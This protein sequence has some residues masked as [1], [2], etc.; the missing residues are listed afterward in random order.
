M[1]NDKINKLTNWMFLGSKSRIDRWINK[2]I[3]W[4]DDKKMIR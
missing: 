4:L 1:N 3:N 2:L